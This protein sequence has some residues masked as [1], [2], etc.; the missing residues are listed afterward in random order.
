MVSYLDRQTAQVEN[1]NLNWSTTIN[2]VTPNYTQIRDWAV[3]SGR[4]LTPE[5]ERSAALVCLLGNTVVQNLFGE[6]Q[7]PVGHHY[8]GEE[9]RDESG[10]RARHQR[11]IGDGTGPG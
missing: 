3:V 8:P 10:R 1:S 7:D 5:D 11:P 2:G 6:H 4:E 9:R